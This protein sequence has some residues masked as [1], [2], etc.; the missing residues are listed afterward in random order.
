MGVEPFLYVADPE[1]LKQMSGSVLVNSNVFR[2]LRRPILELENM[3]LAW[4]R[5]ILGFVIGILLLQLFLPST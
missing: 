4:W 3:V 5:V 1:F 2:S